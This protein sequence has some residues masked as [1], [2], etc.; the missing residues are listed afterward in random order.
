MWATKCLPFGS[1]GGWVG[2]RGEGEG[3]FDNMVNGSECVWW[4]VGWE[5]G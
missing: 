2:G 5:E 4:C 3:R 1:T